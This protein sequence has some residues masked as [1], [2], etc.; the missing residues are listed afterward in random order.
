MFD[1]NGNLVMSLI[2]EYKSTGT[3]SI[4]WNTMNNGGQSVSAGTSF[5]SIELG[6]FR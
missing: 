3:Y 4:K 6:N 1:I 5:Y 2:S